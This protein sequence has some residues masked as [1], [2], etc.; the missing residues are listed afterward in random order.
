MNGKKKH[1]KDVEL[2]VNLE[3]EIWRDVVGYEGMY[4]VS[5]KGRVASLRKGDFRLLHPHITKFGYCRVVLKTRPTCKMVFVHRLVA[6]SFIPNPN[7]LEFIN[8]KDENGTNN[9]VENLEWCTTRYNNTYGTALQRAHETRVRNGVAHVIIAY[10][11]NGTPLAR[12]ESIRRAA[13]AVGCSDGTME[14]CVNGRQL[15]SNGMIYLRE[16]DSIEGRIAEINSH[17]MALKRIA[18]YRNLT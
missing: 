15:T 4:K 2:V 10:D 6:E 16:T 11:L 9:L 18:R 17:P 1:N 3:G 13:R 5:N 12:Y 14:W 8:H 7:A